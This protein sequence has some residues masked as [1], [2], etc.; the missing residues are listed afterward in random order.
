MNDE[1]DYRGTQVS[2]LSPIG[3]VPQDKADEGAI[4]SVLALIVN[5]MEFFDSV[6]SLG[7]D[8][9]EFSVREQLRVN[10]QVKFHLSEFKEVLED[11]LESLRG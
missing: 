3:P 4:K 11:A 1:L 9:R 5:R 6:D 2:S 10:K 7:T 8:E